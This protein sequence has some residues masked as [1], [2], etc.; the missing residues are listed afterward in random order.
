MVGYCVNVRDM[1]KLAFFTLRS[2]TSSFQVVCIAKSVIDELRSIDEYSLIEVTGVVQEKQRRREQD[3]LELELNA[4]TLSRV[5]RDVF[6]SSRLAND[7]TSAQEIFKRLEPIVQQARLTSATRKVLD[8]WAITEFPPPTALAFPD[9]QALAGLGRTDDSPKRY[10]PHPPFHIYSR[11]LAAG[12][13]YRFAFF[14]TTASG[15]QLLHIA[16]CRPDSGEMAAI[17]DELADVIFSDDV[18]GRRPKDGGPIAGKL[19]IGGVQ[20]VEPIDAH[21]VAPWQPTECWGSAGMQLDVDA[22]L[23]DRDRQLSAGFGLSERQIFYRNGAAVAHSSVVTQDFIEMERAATTLG[24]TA[25]S[26]AAWRRIFHAGVPQPIP[27]MGM[28]TLVIDGLPDNACAAARGHGE[29]Q[30]RAAL[31][32]SVDLA[33]SDA[34]N[35]VRAAHVAQLAEAEQLRVELEILRGHAPDLGDITSPMA[36]EAALQIIELVLPAYNLPLDLVHRLLD[37]CRRIHPDWRI[38]RPVDLFQM[39]WTLV[40]S[41]SVKSVL[42]S[43]SSAIESIHRLIEHRIISD[44][45]QLL[46]LY[47]AVPPAIDRLLRDLT[48]DERTMF[49]VQLRTLLAQRPTLFSTAVQTLAASGEHREGRS[50]EAVEGLFRSVEAGIATPLLVQM[51]SDLGNDY[52]SLKQLQH[53]LRKTGEAVFPNEPRQPAEVTA[54]F[55]DACPRHIVDSLLRAGLSSSDELGREI[56]Y[57]LYRPVTMDY[58]MFR[59]MLNQLSDR[60]HD[61]MSWGIIGH[62]EFWNA[63]LRCYEY[64]LD[65]G[66]GQVGKVRLYWSKNVGSFFAKSTAG[67]CTDINVE[68]FNRP[69]H[70]HLNI[71]DADDGRAVGN[72]QLYRNE[73]FGGRFLMVRGINPIQGFCVNYG[74]DQLVGC[75]FHAICDLAAFGGFSEVRLCEQNG[76]WNSDSSRAEVRACLKRICAEMPLK[77][78]ERVFHLYDYYGRA[79]NVN[80]YYKIWE[81]SSGVSMSPVSKDRK[82]G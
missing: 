32:P 37:L 63:T 41:A 16:V 7:S 40:G 25:Y 23:T 64:C 57:Y 39:L 22:V 70:Y 66:M 44:K 14:S 55:V 38:E 11:L 24:D 60:T 20:P 15:W 79:L 62:G 80:A 27:R 53:A 58:A 72:V 36:L 45:R 2:Q 42:D 61:W 82:K 54:A 67:I 78:M 31:A 13:L 3:R 34:F 52:G 29:T 17:L 4:K 77:L 69:D 76:L 74:V 26:A 48:G 6:H 18:D 33:T 46:Y 56:L 51:T 19:A 47:P 81:P 30:L 50:Q 35:R 43:S 1:G 65:R 59:D 9:M 73:G 21:L 28:L 75:I 49:I 68:L 10:C 12:G 5:G 8:A 71:V